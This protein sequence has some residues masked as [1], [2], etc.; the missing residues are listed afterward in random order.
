MIHRHYH[1]RIN[2][3]NRSTGD[4]RVDVGIDDTQQPLLQ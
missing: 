3:Y 2:E 4:L 1:G